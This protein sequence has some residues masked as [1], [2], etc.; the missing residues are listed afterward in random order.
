[1]LFAFACT[2]TRCAVLLAN[3]NGDVCACVLCVCACAGTGR[4]DQVCVQRR[5]PTITK[6]T[7]PITSTKPTITKP[8]FT[9]TKPTTSTTT[10]RTTTQNSGVRGCVTM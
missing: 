6:P 5:R 7:T 1:M 9:I 3:Y 8:T 10:A 2:Q 4:D